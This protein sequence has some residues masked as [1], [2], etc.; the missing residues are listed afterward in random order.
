MFSLTFF[1]SFFLFL[2]SVNGALRRKGGGEEEEGRRRGVDLSLL[3]KTPAE[4]GHCL[5]NKKRGTFLSLYIYIYMCA[6]VCVL[7]LSSVC[8]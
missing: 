8:D 4:I 3:I 2:K 7:A 1:L 5:D 6:Y